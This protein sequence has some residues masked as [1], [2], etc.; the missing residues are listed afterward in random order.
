MGGN[1]GSIQGR[2]RC[3]HK[4]ASRSLIADL[5]RRWRVGDRFE[6][7]AEV[8]VDRCRSGGDYR[9]KWRFRSWLVWLRF[10]AFGFLALEQVCG[11]EG[12]W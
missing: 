11:L 8:Y 10:L 6:D 2:L 5:G 1:G 9:Y 12:K 4:L 7:A 3:D